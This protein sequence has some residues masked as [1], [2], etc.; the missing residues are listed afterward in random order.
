MTAVMAR[1]MVDWGTPWLSASSTCT[2]LRRKVLQGHQH[3]P[4]KTQDR[5]EGMPV[6]MLLQLLEQSVELVDGDACAIVHTA[7]RS[8]G[9][10][11]QDVF[12]SER[13]APLVV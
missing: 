13:A 10:Y 9:I 5:R 2:R 6:E 11:F 12:L 7:A 8:S 1:L 4:W 3:R